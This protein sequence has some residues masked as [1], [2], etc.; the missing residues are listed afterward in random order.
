MGA[1]LD[2]DVPHKMFARRIQPFGIALAEVSWRV[3]MFT[4][5][6]VVLAAIYLEE[7]NLIVGM[8]FW[9]D[10]EAARHLFRGTFEIGLCA[11]GR[12]AG[13]GAS[14]GRTRYRNGRRVVHGRRA[15]QPASKPDQRQPGQAAFFTFFIRGFSRHSPGLVSVSQLAGRPPRQARG[16][17][18]TGRLT[19]GGLRVCSPGPL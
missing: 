15:A 5:D 2:V 10:E 11:D 14:G 9:Q 16:P 8:S 6:G 17:A 3:K 19:S 7:P 13:P 12:P 18:H 1:V 4:H